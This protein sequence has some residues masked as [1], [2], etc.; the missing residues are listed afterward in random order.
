MMQEAETLLGEGL[1]VDRLSELSLFVLAGL[2]A[3]ANPT[4]A[5]PLRGGVDW[6]CAAEGFDGW[7]CHQHVVAALIPLDG[8]PAARQVD[9]CGTAEVVG[10]D[11]GDEDGTRAAATGLGGA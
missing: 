10:E 5:P 8:E 6:E 2:F 9:A 3:R 1:W 4:P 7:A 11:A